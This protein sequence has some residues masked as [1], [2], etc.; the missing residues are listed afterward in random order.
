VLVLHGHYA[1]CVGD[2]PSYDAFTLGGPYS[3]RGYG[4]G[5]LGASRNVLEVSIITEL[6]FSF[7]CII[8]VTNYVMFFT[9]KSTNCLF[10]RFVH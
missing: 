10:F 1:G 6:E 3:V 4:M 9:F 7:R 8:F 5:E 2:L